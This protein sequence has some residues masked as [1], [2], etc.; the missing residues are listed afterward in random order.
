MR[1]HICFALCLVIVALMICSSQG[2]I[3]DAHTTSQSTVLDGYTYTDSSGGTYYYLGGE[4]VGWSIDEGYHTN[5]TIVTYSFD[6]SDAYLT[7]SLKNTFI[8]GASLWSGV[9][10]F[11]NSTSGTGIVSTVYN[12]SSVIASFENYS[13]DSNGH[14]THWSIKLNRYYTQT[15]R[16]IA[17]ELG[18]VIGLNDLYS[19]FNSD[20]L[21]FGFSSGSATA[22]TLQDIWGA[23]VIL[24]IH[25]SHS[26]DYRYSYTDS[27]GVKYHVNYCTDCAG[28]GLMVNRCVFIG[29]TCR[30]C[31]VN[32]YLS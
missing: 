32:R 10:S 5:G 1:K 14:L 27:S 12:S 8:N 25:T 26:W 2:N 9:V 28:I 31:G 20:K 21:M 16:I 18:H 23:K 29:D 24:G 3:I 13:A 6:D 7:S 19:T 17:H 11:V 22:P 30:I 4:P 15:P